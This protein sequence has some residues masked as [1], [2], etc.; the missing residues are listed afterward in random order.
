MVGGT[1]ASSD[2]PMSMLRADDED[3]RSG[4]EVIPAYLASHSGLQ[5][6][7]PLL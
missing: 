5:Q 4:L 7:T 1:F 6:K 3:W 2:M